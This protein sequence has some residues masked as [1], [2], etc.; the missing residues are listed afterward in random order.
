MLRASRCLL[1]IVLALDAVQAATPG[2]S[3]TMAARGNVRYGPNK[4]API[5]T[6]L[7]PGS[8][9]VV[10]DRI[11]TEWYAIQFPRQGHAW[12]HAKVLGPTE[13]PRR[14]RVLVDQAHVRADSRIKAELVAQLDRGDVVEWVGAELDGVWQGRKIGDWYA[15]YPPSAVAYCHASVLALTTE[16]TAA[17]QRQ[18]HSQHAAEQA[19]QKAKAAYAERYAALQRDQQA[20]LR[21]D[22]EELASTLQGVVADHPR[23]RTRL[24]AEKL[25]RVIRRVQAASAQAAAGGSAVT[26]LPEPEPVAAETPVV[27]DPPAV[28]DTPPPAGAE[29]QVQ[30]ASPAEQPPGTVALPAPVAVAEPEPAGS[31][32]WLM[33][34]DVPGGLAKHVLVDADSRVTALIVSG[35]LAEASFSDYFWRKVGVSGPSRSVSIEMDGATQIVPL[36]EAAAIRMVP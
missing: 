14:L 5:V 24:D 8:E 7:S 26:L 3:V 27:A 32:G 17:T 25:L 35:G 31:S 4:D 20:G 23:L 6:T 12:M 2:V 13:D 28:A 22:W 36:I 29:T 16:Q 9:V 30:T 18:Q 21:Q 11:G 19:W 33:Q 1:L 34:R 15:V 10:V